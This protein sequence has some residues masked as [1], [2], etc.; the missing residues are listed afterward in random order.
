MN[1]TLVVGLN[2]AAINAIRG[3]GARS[4]YIFAEGNSWT[5]A[6]TWPTVNDDMK[7][8]FDPS[9]RLVYEMHQYLDSDGSGTSA[10]CVN[11][12]IGAERL[13]AATAWLK[14]HRKQAILGEFA[15]GDNEVCQEAVT[16]MLSLMAK[17]TDVWKGA[18]WWAAGPWWGDYIYS[19][20]PPSG[21]AYTG[22]WSTLKAFF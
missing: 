15:G 10:T 13:T 9:D 20:E 18:I 21:I 4:Q 7:Y 2:Q 11:S 6:W 22:M 1:E 5:G 19:I 16:G 17:N 3:V 14:Q 8:L 12:T